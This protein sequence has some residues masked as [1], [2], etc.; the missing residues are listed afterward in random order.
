MEQRMF[1]DMRMT[2][3]M[4]MT[5]R[6]QQ[7]IKML[8]MPTIE[9]EALVEQELLEN[10]VLE[11]LP[12]EDLQNAGT[13][14]PETSEREEVSADKQETGDKEWDTSGEVADRDLTEGDKLS[15][16]R[17]ELNE[18]WE[19]FFEDGS[20][21]YTTT[22]SGFGGPLDEDFDRVI[23]DE[24]SLRED[25]KRQL[26]IAIDDE[27]DLEIGLTILNSLDG[28]GYLPVT[29]AEIAEQTGRSEED[30]ERVL[31]VV[32]TFDPPGIG[33]R[34]LSECLEIQYHA[35]GMDSPLMLEIMRNHIADL[36][37]KRY[38]NIGRALKITVQEV[39]V[40]ADE[41]SRFEPR[42]GRKLTS[43]E[44]EYV[45]PDVFVEKVDGSWQVRLNDDGIAP[46]RISP[47]YR[48]MLESKETLDRETLKY[49]RSRLHSAVDLIKNIE[50]RKQTLYK[51][52]Q[53]IVNQQ[54][55]FLEEGVS[56]LK[57]MRLRDVADV[58]GVHETTVCR[59]VNG[60]YVETPQGLYE[61]KYFFS[62]GL[63]SEG[64]ENTSA[65]SVMALVQEMV[66]NEDPKKP[67]SDQKISDLLKKKGINIARRTVAK[68]R[69]ILGILPTSMRKRV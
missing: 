35:E 4:V 25:L 50:Q 14:D 2:Q 68:Y 8:Q 28:D 48:Q 32:H 13:T 18:D 27:S 56:Q 10:P 6:M 41:I 40:L 7:A 45:T 67:L 9:L 22:P 3:K 51:V 15:E 31:K 60:K 37:H 55:G 62:G 29:V 43:F 34:D 49:I 61:L 33:A 69:D 52:T 38:Q 53:E 46:L 19:K 59:V 17:I 65:K 39:Q 36:E 42:P 16:G 11:E 64:A 1:L 21:S 44:N 30:V 5:P 57:P 66:D 54:E 12:L 23:P 20:D 63:D 47:K 26:E 24:V 58:V